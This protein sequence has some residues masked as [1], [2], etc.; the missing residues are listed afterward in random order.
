MVLLEKPERRPGLVAH[1]AAYRRAQISRFF[2]TPLDHCHI[3]AG[4]FTRTRGAAQGLIGAVSQDA[5]SGLFCKTLRTS[6]SWRRGIRQNTGFRFNALAGLFSEAFLAH[7]FA[8]SG[9]PFCILQAHLRDLDATS[10]GLAV[11]FLHTNA[12]AQTCRV[13]PGRFTLLDDPLLAVFLVL[14][15]LRIDRIRIGLGEFERFPRCLGC[16]GIFSLGAN[17]KNRQ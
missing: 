4:C 11:A 10:F 7:A 2:Q 9:R 17:G 3:I 15:G 8:C 6:R 14:A 5:A 12:A 13:A 1:R 16:V